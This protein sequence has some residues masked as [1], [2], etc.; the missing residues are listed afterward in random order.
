MSLKT[1]DTVWGYGERA[2]AL[3]LSSG[4]ARRAG[5]SPVIPISGSNLGGSK[6]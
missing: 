6:T 4:A 5:S 2:D 1:K 3:V